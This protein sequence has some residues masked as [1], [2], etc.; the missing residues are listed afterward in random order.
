LLGAVA[1]W[2]ACWGVNYAR[3]AAMA[4]GDL[5]GF[6]ETVLNMS[7]WVLPK[8]ADL[9]LLLLNAVQAQDTFGQA[10]ALRAAIERRTLVPE[11]SLLTTCLLPAVV[12][13]VAARR[14]VRAQY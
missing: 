13:A 7:Y 14:F 10:P 6:A 9:G 4:N 3:H 2:L 1:F 12:F 11:L 8:P 5:G